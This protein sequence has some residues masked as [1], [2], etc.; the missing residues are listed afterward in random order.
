[1]RIQG[2]G[3]VKICLNCGGESRNIIITLTNIA[4]M[5]GLHT[6][7]IGARRLKQAGYSWD[8][9][10]NIIKKGN[11]TVFKIRDHLSGLWV[12]EQ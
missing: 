5:P 3:N 7:I 11:N 12:V 8:F 10:N 9:D 6:N 4:Y 1:M 2:T